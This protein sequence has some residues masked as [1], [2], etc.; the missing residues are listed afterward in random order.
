VRPIGETGA[1][2]AAHKSDW[3]ARV[4]R[5][6]RQRRE[7]GLWRTPG[8]HDGLIDLGGNGY[9]GL[10]RDPRVIAA[11]VRAA[12]EQG[13]SAG[14]SRLAGGSLDLHHDVEQTFAEFK[15]AEA[16]AI[17]PTGYMANIAALTALVEPDDL[18]L[19][20]KL[21]HASIL[22]AAALC[23]ARRGSPGAVMRAFPHRDLSRAEA[24]AK[25]YLRRS[26]K[27]AVWLVS[28]SVFSMD[29]DTA[30]VAGLA[31]L[32]DMPSLRALEPLDEASDGT[33][34]ASAA[35]DAFADAQ[36]APGQAVEDAADGPPP[37]PT[38]QSAG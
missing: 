13:V 25:R 15:G 23:A 4:R 18:I 2:G 3:I 6:L 36:D 38:L 26:P 11:A 16:A 34:G 21:N 22:D 35:D 28:D 32:R 33:R 12:S 30:D 14:A 37:G 1:S 20:D 5:R 10:R 8:R 27:T 17:L 19:C 9:L 31:S 24:I 29:G 7:S